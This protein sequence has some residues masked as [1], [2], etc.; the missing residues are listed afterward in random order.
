MRHAGRLSSALASVEAEIYATTPFAVLGLVSPAAD[1][2]VT[3]DMRSRLAVTRSVVKPEELPEPLRRCVG[4]PLRVSGASPAAQAASKVDLL[5]AMLELESLVAVPLSD[6]G[7]LLFVA[8]ARPDTLDETH[9][10]A[11]TDLARR[12]AAMPQQEDTPAD[13]ERRL[14]Q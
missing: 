11:A 8:S 10:A 5:F 7:G 6:E 13:L 3:F 2:R 4:V 12:L 1:G 9:V 14:L